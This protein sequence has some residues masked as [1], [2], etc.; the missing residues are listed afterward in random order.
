MRAG[1]L[2][3]EAEFGAL[4]GIQVLKVNDLVGRPASPGNAELDHVDAQGLDLD[5]LLVTPACVRDGRITHDSD[6]ILESAG[7][8]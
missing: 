3:A 8:A 2:D 6:E 5:Q 1:L 7:V 4:L